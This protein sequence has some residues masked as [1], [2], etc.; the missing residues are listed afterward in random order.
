MR[1]PFAGMLM[2]FWPVW[3]WLALSSMDG[4]NESANLLAAAT[5]ILLAWRAP[6]EGSIAYPLALPTVCVLL[7]T[8][9]CLAG[10]SLSVRA[11]C[12][13]LALGSLAS[14]VRLGKRL[15]LAM[16][17]LCMLA[18]PVAAS[19]QYYLGY[20][21]RVMAGT[22]SVAMLHTNGI[23]VVREGAMLAWDG[24]LLAIDAP[25]SG[26]KMLWAGL[27]L[28]CT[29]AGIRGLAAPNTILAVAAAIGIVV[30]ANAMRAAALF[31]LETGMVIGPAWAHEAIGIF[32][33]AIAA[34][35]I[36]GMTHSFKK[37]AA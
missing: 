12:A 8:M 35:A 17:A 11:A 20:P 31:Y 7:Y 5:A 32:C 2:A 19:L 6:A 30:V 9:A 18:L 37:V 22:L 24:Q 36:Y 21:L 29:L 15:D 16:L 27:Y 14:A 10:L 23:A 1:L 33:F 13:A 26:V 3:Q 4:S 34:L 25:C 28:A